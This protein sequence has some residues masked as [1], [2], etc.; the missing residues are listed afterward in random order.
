MHNVPAMTDSSNSINQPSVSAEEQIKS[1]ASIVERLE[2]G[3]IKFSDSVL[4]V[5]TGQPQTAAPKA[6]SVAPATGAKR[7]GRPLGSVNRVKADA[8]VARVPHPTEIQIA[9][10]IDKAG[11]MTQSELA[12]A[13]KVERALIQNHTD[14]L[15]ESGKIKCMY[16][17][18]PGEHRRLVYYRPDWV[19][20]R[21][22]GK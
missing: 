18:L 9:A 14:P 11:C 7:R 19:K 20:E 6:A 4:Q 15:L 12:D 10:L 8:P 13:L 2:T 1:I 5:L 3:M 21:S 22:R 16:W 17:K